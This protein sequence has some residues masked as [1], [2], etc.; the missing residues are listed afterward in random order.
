MIMYVMP[1]TDGIHDDGAMVQKTVRLPKSIIKSIDSTG[2][3][4]SEVIRD[5]LRAYFGMHDQLATMSDV[6]RCIEAHQKTYH[7]REAIIDNLAKWGGVQT[8][9]DQV[10]AREQDIKTGIIPMQPDQEAPVQEPK[11]YERAGKSDKDKDKRYRTI[12]ILES[13]LR[14]LANDQEVVSGTIA[15]DTGIEAKTIGRTLN[16]LGME[17]MNTRIH[18]ISGRY[19]GFANEDLAKKELERLKAELKAEAEGKVDG[20]NE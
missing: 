3:P 5:A 8:V 1:Q 20:G 15:K 10:A 17:P 12:T 7:T 19:W 6:I 18:N 13:L 16:E 4:D 2:R 11:R 14:F 9:M